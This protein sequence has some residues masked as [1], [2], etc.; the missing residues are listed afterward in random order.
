MSRLPYPSRRSLPTTAKALYALG[1]LAV[2][3]VSMSLGGAESAPTRWA[4]VVIPVA[5]V[6]AA[7][8]VSRYAGREIRR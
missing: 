1:I 7:S 6:A 3:A 4:T 8:T 5:L 2:V